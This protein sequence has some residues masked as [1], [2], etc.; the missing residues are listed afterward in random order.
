MPKALAIAEEALV[1]LNASL[2]DKTWTENFEI[3]ANT[4]GLRRVEFD[5]C[6]YILAEASKEDSR[7]VIVDVDILA[8]VELP[9]DTLSRIFRA[10]ICKF[11]RTSA[12]PTNWQPFHEGSFFSIYVSNSRL[13]THNQKL[14]M[15]AM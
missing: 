13:R 11:D 12:L 4:V 9:A 14:T 15:A 5:D 3:P 1:R 2:I 8:E 7:F 10:G 6:I